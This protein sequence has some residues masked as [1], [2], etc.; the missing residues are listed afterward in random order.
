MTPDLRQLR[1][2]VAV[3]EELHFSRAA[4]RLHMAQPPLSQQINELERKLGVQLFVR[5]TRRVELTPAGSAFLAGARRVLAEADR[6]VE[7]AQRAS[8]GEMETLRVSFADAAA[9]SVLPQAVRL[10]REAFPSVHLEMRED[11]GAAEQFDAVRRDLVDVALARGPLV[12][13]VLHV[14]VLLE[15]PFCIALW[16]GHPLAELPVIPLPLLAELPFVLFPR[17]LSPVYYDQLVGMCQNAGFTPRVVFEVAKVHSTFSLVA[18]RAGVAF[19]PRSMG[20]LLLPDVVVRELSGCT[21]TAQVVAA[22][23]PNR[24][25]VALEGLLAALREPGLAAARAHA[26]AVDG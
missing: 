8:R 22:Y 6:A 5:S 11:A 25:S 17:H 9:L 4:R 12:D 2:F 10:F 18:A 7:V 23:R 3:A 20:T 14:E 26:S 13:Q 24:P 21:A 19:I 15:E 16:K 1:Y